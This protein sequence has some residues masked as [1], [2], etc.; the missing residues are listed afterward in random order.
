MLNDLVFVLRRIKE[1]LERENL[2][3][4]YSNLSSYVQQASQAHTPELQAQI[5]DSKEK[6]KSAHEDLN[7]MGWSHT[8]TQIFTK[9]G[10]AEILGKIGLEKFEKTFNDNAGVPTAVT[11]ELSQQSQLISQLLTNVNNILS[12]LGNLGEVDKS[13]SGKGVVQ[14]VF[15]DGV[16]VNNLPDLSKQSR[17]WE[18]ILRAYSILADESPEETKIL[19]SNK[20]NPFFLWLSTAPLISQAI[21]H[22]V[23]P[24]IDLWHEVLGL[25]EHALALKEKEIAVA[26]EELKLMNNIDE[27]EKKKI[28]E[29]LEAVA[30]KYSKKDLEKAKLNDGKVNLLKYGPEIYEFIKLNGEVDASENGESN[31]VTSNLKLANKYIETQKLYTKVQKMLESSNQK[32]KE[33][34]SK[35]GEEEDSKKTEE[36]SVKRKSK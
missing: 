32:S 30:D 17:N 22:T 12:S 35:N 8:Q 13:E 1:V 26:G 18:Q 36:K 5:N 15:K 21:F 27:Y 9:F 16:A 34:P 10:A 3:T 2:P 25:K 28:N 14:I 23:K 31:P 6:I 29:I 4:I 24:F 33:V 19:A 20:S 11:A 7:T